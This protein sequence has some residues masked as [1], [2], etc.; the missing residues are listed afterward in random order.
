MGALILIC[1]ILLPS[2]ALIGLCKLS[3]WIVERRRE[4]KSKERLARMWR[5][6]GRD[7]V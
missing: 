4:K 3:D 2:L 5:R 1:Y 7:G 6:G